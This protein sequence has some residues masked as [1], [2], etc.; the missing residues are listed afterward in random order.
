VRN[1]SCD[2]AW[3]YAA[4]LVIASVLMVQAFSSLMEIACPRSK[5]LE[6]RHLSLFHS[7]SLIYR[8]IVR[9]KMSPRRITIAAIL[10]VVIGFNSVRSR[11]SLRQRC[12]HNR[13]TSQYIPFSHATI[14]LAIG[15]IEDLQPQASLFM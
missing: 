9:Q 5:C 7:L 12:R 13:I 6:P 2:F 15:L 1:A 11:L 4:F 14:H 8:T 10:S 3:P